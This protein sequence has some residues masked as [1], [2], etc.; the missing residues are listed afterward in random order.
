MLGRMAPQ[1]PA[2]PW[3]K[4]TQVNKF[5]ICGECGECWPVETAAFGV[6]LGG[7]P[8]P[9]AV[10]LHEYESATSAYLRLHRLS[11]AAEMLTRFVTAVGLAYLHE[12][13]RDFSEG[14][15]AALARNLQLPS[16]GA[17]RELLKETCQGLL[18]A[19]EPFKSMFAWAMESLYPALGSRDA[20]PREG[21]VSM[22]NLLA[23]CGRLP[24][25]ESERLLGIH[26][27]GFAELLSKAQVFEQLTLIARDPQGH[28]RELRGHLP[29][30]FKLVDGARRGEAIRA[31]QVAI[32][33][34]N[35][36]VDLFPLMIY[37]DGF[38]ARD[39][40][41][42]AAG[43]DEG[44]Q[45]VQVAAASPSLQVY[46]RKEAEAYLDFTCLAP[47]VSTTQR[48]L[49]AARR[50]DEVF[51][52]RAWSQELAGAEQHKKFSF[53]DRISELSNVPI[54]RELSE[55]FIGRDDQVKAISSWAR[56][57]D[58]LCWL[59]G[60]PGI[61]KSA[62]MARLAR[63][64]FTDARVF[65]K[66]A[67]FF[68]STDWRCNLPSFLEN[69]VSALAP[70]TTP[71]QSLLELLD[72]AAQAIRGAAASR[73]VVLLLDG[74]DEIS[75][76]ERRLIPWI[77][78][79]Q[80]PNICWVCAGREDAEASW[81]SL[82]H[83]PFGPE[84]LPPLRDGHVRAFLDGKC[85]TKIYE[86]C[87]RDAPDTAPGGNKNA[88]LAALMERS[89]GLPLYLTMLIRDINE[90]RLSFQ[91]GAEHELPRGL[92]EYYGE[93]LERLRI[94]DTA[95]LLAPVFAL[96]A[97]AKAPLAASVIHKLMSQ[98][99]LLRQPGGEAL[100]AGV[101]RFGHLMLRA[102]SLDTGELGVGSAAEA[103]YSLYHQSFRTH[104]LGSPLVRAAVSAARGDFCRLAGEFRELPP[105][106]PRAYALRYGPLHLA[107]EGDREGVLALVTDPSWIFA[108]LRLFGPEEIGH[109]LEDLLA[110]EARGFLAGEG[111]VWAQFLRSRAH[112]FFRGGAVAFLQI[113][114]LEPVD[115]V[116]GRALDH[117]LKREP[118]G[119]DWLAPVLSQRRS[120][121]LVQTF[122]AS[123]L[124]L[125][126][127]LAPSGELVAAA[128]SRGAIGWSI[129]VGRRVWSIDDVAG[130]LLFTSS[131]ERLLA[132]NA[133]G[134]LG[135]YDAAR[136]N[137]L[138]AL[139]L[140]TEGKAKIA[141]M[142][143]SGDDRL[144]IALLESGEL[145]FWPSSLEGP[146]RFFQTEVSMARKFVPLPGGGRVW[147][148]CWPGGVSKGGHALVEVDLHE[149]GERRRWLFPRNVTGVLPLSEGR[150]LIGF[151]NG[152]GDESVELWSLASAKATRLRVLSRGDW[153]VP[154]LASPD[155]RLAL[156][157]PGHQAYLQI[158]DIHSATELGREDLPSFGVRGFSFAGG[159]LAT[160]LD[161]GAL[162][163]WDT[164][165][166]WEKVA[167]AAESQG[168]GWLKSLPKSLRSLVGREE[169]SP[170]RPAGRVGS[171]I[172]SMAVSGD[173][174][175]LASVA[176]HGDVFLRDA[177][178]GEVVGTLPYE[179]ARHLTFVD[180]RRMLMAL[181]EREGKVVLRSLRDNQEQLFSCHDGEVIAVAMLPD[182]QRF[183]TIGMDGPAVSA[184]ARLKVWT[185]AGRCLAVHPWPGSGVMALAA[186]AA[187][188]VIL[189]PPTSLGS[190]VLE[191][192]DV[193]TGT[194]VMRVTDTTGSSVDRT[195]AI[196]SMP[197]G[198]F[199][200]SSDTSGLVRRWNLGALD[201]ICKQEGCAQVSAM[202]MEDE[203]AERCG[204]VYDLET[205]K[206]LATLSGDELVRT[207]SLHQGPVA[208]LALA[209]GGLV[210]TASL[211]GSAVLF[212]GTLGRVVARW[213]HDVGL[214]ACAS[215]GSDLL[216]LGDAQGRIL[217]LRHHR[218]AA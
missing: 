114:A 18:K 83:L 211:D 134:A 61:G 216:V 199:V 164:G 85:G 204:H 37:G 132:L 206:K 41:R 20:T 112:V 95:A 147:V 6:D 74:L 71:K 57:A 104:L 8:Y 42:G 168:V 39:R 51:Q 178:T 66:V 119:V 179:R 142:H 146:A 185:L 131:P 101:L 205:N 162:Q 203:Q 78:S 174:Q 117:W 23:H 53:L 122:E 154:V 99:R 180:D 210:L 143:R 155:E 22:R 49:Q 7:W 183:L 72:Q 82:A 172:L 73:R 2:H 214:Y 192:V 120:R 109:L 182:G 118:P 126:C 139:E 163:L 54:G 28:L 17:W 157:A 153:S 67:H 197:G 76:T 64:F 128:G 34:V 167:S 196:L 176:I 159:K 215:L 165:E 70:A 145:V 62:V 13:K 60:P 59:H 46:F 100:L 166:L 156:V 127:A 160:L 58:G 29:E 141:M 30:R 98:D 33:G 75:A 88:F 80:G 152:G 151:G 129:K 189:R 68:I 187:R 207:F 47:S 124:S 65:A 103:G 56:T 87:S 212:D 77:R 150:A 181:R 161:S 195:L 202:V 16:F 9:L 10:A 209:H 32:Y 115:S 184:E 144:V 170:S 84:G 50:F 86:L 111:Q 105:G 208:D 21:I 158:W 138:A 26:V 79:L 24:E 69:V 91:A 97:V 186:C 25:E 94:S 108:R 48:G 201:R 171:M 3:L 107:D 137:L 5:W 190:G 43:G 52:L 11:S 96:L 148:W 15:K 45:F 121:G 193:G 31:D 213:E 36:G 110:L 81:G 116:I 123:P 194:V 188:A 136:G 12:R 19:P 89:A 217:L 135:V 140:P 149:L 14:V 130:P 169:K 133:S 4:P 35:E 63:G 218:R 177:G 27:V 191:A 93:L 173:R 175:T 92:D 55:I 198:K 40:R 106:P 113:A 200:L 38:H 125:S 90:G 1:C 102:V 44:G